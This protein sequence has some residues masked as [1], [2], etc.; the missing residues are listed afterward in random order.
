MLLNNAWSADALK[1]LVENDPYQVTKSGVPY[2][3]TI[4]ITKELLRRLNM[5]TDLMVVP[6]ARGYA[7]TKRGPNVALLAAARTPEREHLFKWVGPLDRVSYALY[8]KKE[9]KI[10]ITSLEQIKNAAVIGVVRGSVESKMLAELGAENLDL[11]NS[12]MLNAKMLMAGRVDLMPSSPIAINSIMASV[13]YSEN[14]VRLVAYI[15]D[16]VLYLMVSNDVA[17]STIVLMQNTLNDIKTEGLFDQY[18]RINGQPMPVFN[19]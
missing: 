1:V 14:E 5:S 8:A 12:Q 7:M 11:A 13:G 15:E 4:D 6:W 3:A 19:Q 9:S 18:F 2:S 10:E 17:D 16:T